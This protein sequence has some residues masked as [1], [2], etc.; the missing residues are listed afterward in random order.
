M[1]KRRKIDADDF[2]FPSQASDWGSRE[3]GVDIRTY[4]AAK[5]MEA[6]IIRLGPGAYNAELAVEEADRLIA[7]LNK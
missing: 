5:A 3:Y 6:L 7:E 4:I 1:V 2:A